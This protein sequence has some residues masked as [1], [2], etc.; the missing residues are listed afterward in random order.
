MPRD[1][2]ATRDAI[3]G[4][5]KEWAELVSLR[6]SVLDAP[7]D[8]AAERNLVARLESHREKLHALRSSILE[9]STAS[10]PSSGPSPVRL[11]HTTP[12]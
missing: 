6:R 12:N 11:A 1:V 2:A 5:H 8:E 3:C 4:L 10:R 7:Y 9:D